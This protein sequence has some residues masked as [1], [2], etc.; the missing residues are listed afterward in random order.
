MYL[1]C[2]ILMNVDAYCVTRCLYWR[3]TVVFSKALL[4]GKRRRS[5]AL[6]L[7]QDPVITPELVDQALSCIC[8]N[9]GYDRAKI[10]ELAQREVESIT[11]LGKSFGKDLMALC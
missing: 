6:L 9:R 3:K 2:D 4:I 5:V 11:G 1:S 8:V 10:Y 7:A